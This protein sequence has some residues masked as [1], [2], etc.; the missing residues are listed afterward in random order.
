MNGFA[1]CLFLVCPCIVGNKYIGS[2]GQADENIYEKVNE[3]TG[4]SYRRKCLMT[5]KMADHHNVGSIE[6]KLQDSG[7]HE[8]NCKF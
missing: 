1:H 8:R 4:A 7:K 2:Y 5:G 6:E 3:G